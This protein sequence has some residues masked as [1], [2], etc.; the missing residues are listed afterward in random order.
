L[1]EF[2]QILGI[3]RDFTLIS[4]SIIFL[5]I[6]VI[7]FKRFLKLFQSFDNISEQVDGITSKFSQKF[8]N[9]VSDGSKLGFGRLI[10]FFLGFKNQD[11]E[12]TKDSSQ[13]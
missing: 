9:P 1:N 6:G 7:L 2:A 4:V 8:I 12:D 13:E 11:K 10:A 3:I 5:I